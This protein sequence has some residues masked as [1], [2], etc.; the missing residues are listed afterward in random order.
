MPPAVIA[1]RAHLRVISTGSPSIGIHKKRFQLIDPP[2]LLVD[3]LRLTPW[4]AAKVELY[5]SWVRY[6][7]RSCA[8]GVSTV[9]R[10]ST[11]SAARD[12]PVVGR[13]IPVAPE[14]SSRPFASN[15]TAAPDKPN[16]SGVHSSGVHRNV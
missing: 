12:S 11:T 4:V 7:L 13:T 16:R 6:R 1:V 9:D 5:D 14:A 10:H 15:S 3:K 8:M 2:I